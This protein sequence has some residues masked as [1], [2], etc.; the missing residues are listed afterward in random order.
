MKQ[1]PGL[2]LRIVLFKV[3]EERRVSQVLETGS[4]VCHPIG[5]SGD[6]AGHMAVAVLALVRACI[7]AEVGRRPV[8]GD[9]ATADPGHRWGVIR[10]VGQGGIPHRMSGCHEGH[11][12]QQASVLQVAIGDG[13][14][15]VVFGHQVVLDL[16]GEGVP[17]KERLACV[18]EVHAAHSGLGSVRRTEQGRLLRNYLGKVSGSL[19]EAGGKGCERV[20]VG[21]QVRIDSHAVVSRAVQCELEGA[22]QGGRSRDGH[23]H[24][25]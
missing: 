2:G 4:V 22:E 11:L 21:S 5:I 23:R 10:Q 20:D 3:G 14:S 1:F 25:T 17:P 8:A 12:G 15:G 18:V 19:A 7:V 6:E 9:G 16:L 13:S 24:E